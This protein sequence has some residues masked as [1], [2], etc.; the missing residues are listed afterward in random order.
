MHSYF[1]KTCTA[2]C[3]HPG[4][5]SIWICFHY[6][7]SLSQYT[8]DTFIIFT[9]PTSSSTADR[10]SKRKRK[11]DVGSGNR[12]SIRR[13][14]GDSATSSSK[15]TSAEILGS[16]C[17]DKNKYI[18]RKENNKT[19]QVTFTCNDTNETFDSLAA[20]GEHFLE[21]EQK[22][23]WME[24]GLAD[25][26]LVQEA[27]ISLSRGGNRDAIRICEEYDID[28]E[29]DEEEGV[30]MPVKSTKKEEEDD[31]EDDD[32]ADD[33]DNSPFG[34][35]KAGYVSASLD[36]EKEKSKMEM[37]ALLSH[38]NKRVIVHYLGIGKCYCYRY[39]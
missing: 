26:E 21:H 33:E 10:S 19:L 20:A 29:D 3:M 15:L 32:D 17:S 36:T 28:I 14:S 7:G 34:L 37:G 39:Y 22:V 8:L 5:S 12:R 16:C 4:F 9:M 25:D 1:Y 31:A 30:G 13:V 38:N 6:F 11:G 2:E 24:D 27:L 35:S 23:Q 18:T